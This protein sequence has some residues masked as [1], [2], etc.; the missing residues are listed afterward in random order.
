MICWDVSGGKIFLPVPKDLLVLCEP[1]QR[2]EMNLNL[3]QSTNMICLNLS[4]S[5]VD[6]QAH[7]LNLGKLLSNHRRQESQ[8]ALGF[9][10]GGIGWRTAESA[11]ICDVKKTKKTRV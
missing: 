1:D 7:R 8:D 4:A 3:P 9:K 6:Y 2:R 11:R 10:P 5:V